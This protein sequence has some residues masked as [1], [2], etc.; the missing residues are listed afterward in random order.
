[1]PNMN[2][3]L[4]RFTA[5]ILAAATEESERSMQQVRALQ[6]A[7]LHDAEDRM[8]REAYLYIHGEVERIKTDSG[9]RVS[10]HML[11]NK[12]ALYLRRDAIAQ[13]VLDL[14]QEKIAAF[15]AT[16]AYALRLESL[17]RGALERLV[18]ATDVEL[19]LRRADLPLGERLRPL[20]PAG[21]NISVGAFRLGGLIAQ[22]QSMG[23]RVDASFDSEAAALS[24]HFAELFGLSLAD[25]DTES[26]AEV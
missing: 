20:L 8:L 25:D 24:G 5:T 14:V 21:A 12:R 11:D 1:M 19:L 22:S 18:G 9:R 3:K 15:T 26:G 23:L 2:K 13:E 4:D 10:R 7:A 16:P 6:D 17:L